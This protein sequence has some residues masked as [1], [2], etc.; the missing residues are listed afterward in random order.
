MHTDPSAAGFSPQRLE[1]MTSHLS[2]NFVSPGKISGCQ[3]MVS[4]RGIPAYFRSFGLADV[5]RNTPITSDTIFRLYSMT[6][7]ITSVALI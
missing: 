3:V 5:E 6:K 7:P 4:R 2:D 1:R